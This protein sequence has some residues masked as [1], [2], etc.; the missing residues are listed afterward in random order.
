MNRLLAAS[1]LVL[2][3]VAACGGSP[4][5]PPTTTPEPAPT[6]KEEPKP[7]PSASATPA[8]SASAPAPEP[9]A[10]AKKPTGSGRPQAIYNDVSEPQTV[11]F[12]GAVFRTSDGAELRIPGGAL[13]EPRNVIFSLDKKAKGTTGVLGKVYQIHVQ[14]PSPLPT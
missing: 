1:P 9:A 4:T 13:S 8:A 3:L 2:F 7:E 12:D 11:G 5:P 6:V 10:T 14:T